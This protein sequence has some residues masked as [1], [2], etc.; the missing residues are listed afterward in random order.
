[1]R[2]Y[3]I[4]VSPV[5]IRVNSHTF[6]L[7]K[8]DGEAYRMVCQY[9]EDIQSSEKDK[10]CI[11]RF[12]AQGCELTDKLLGDGACFQIFGSTPISLGHVAGLC[13]RI[14]GD[15]LR[16]YRQYLKTEYLEAGNEGV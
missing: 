9:L 11:E 5:Q 14:A 1:M 15:C 13:A 12:I 6:S 10:N 16:A 8:S 4:D 3:M 7:Q 2:S